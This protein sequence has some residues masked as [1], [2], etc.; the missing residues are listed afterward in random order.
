MLGWPVIQRG[1][2]TLIISPTG[3]GKTLAAFLAAIDEVMFHRGSGSSECSILYISP[4]K[5]LAAD[6]Q[7]NLREPLYGVAHLATANGAE[8]AMPRVAVR[9]GDTPVAERN[10]FLR[11]GADI[12]ITTPESLFLLLQGRAAARLKSVR[13]VIVDEIHTLAGSKRGAHLALSL[14]RLE[15]LTATP[16]QRIGLS[17][18]VRPV[19]E[20]ARFLGGY[21]PAAYGAEPTINS[22]RPV[23]VVNAHATRDLQVE[24]QMAG[25]AI[26]ADTE[27]PTESAGDSLSALAQQLLDL[28]NGHTS[29]LIFA[30]SRRMAERL[31]AAVNLLAGEELVLAHHGS[32]ARE[33]RLAIEQ[34]LKNGALSALIATSS[35]E[36]GI[37]IGSVDL[38]VQID[39]PPGVASALQRVGRASHQVG[40]TSHG[41]L[42]ARFR[43]DLP[44][45]AALPFLMRT[46]AI[47]PLHIPRNPLDVLAQH[48][49]AMAATT[50]WPVDELYELVRCA[51]PFHELPRG[52]LS[53]TLDMLAGRFPSAAFSGLRARIVW[54]RQL[55]VISGRSGTGQLV[56]ANAGTIPDRGLY[57]VYL[58]TQQDARGRLGE[59]DDH[60]P[61]AGLCNAAS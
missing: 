35:L 5:A 26:P 22:E 23:T 16:F 12:L 53:D 40:R 7:R 54:D 39:A 44:A 36:L 34:D 9:T 8:F 15:H 10:A 21:M 30:N 51:A 18:T 60:R 33:K 49:S 47:E 48:I 28:I 55:G 13:W 59:L 29:T 2:H 17:A 45:C 38:V 27:A 61:R 1:D 42:V 32:V 4:L 11:R 37:D 24:V 6:V 52:L 57:G 3:S 43:G 46:G 19:E 31:A 14:E 50:Q 25:Y 41:I 56:I 20:T 58:T